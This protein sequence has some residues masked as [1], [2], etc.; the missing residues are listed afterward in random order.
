[1]PLQKKVGYTFKN[2]SNRQDI[3]FN[4]YVKAV[5]MKNDEHEKD[6]KIDS[7]NSLGETRAF[8][9]WLFKGFSTFRMN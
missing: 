9:K 2:Y 3:A 8:S 5:K 4:E 6:G 7:L 1:V